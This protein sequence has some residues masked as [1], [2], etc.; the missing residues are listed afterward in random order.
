[1]KTFQVTIKCRNAEGL[2]AALED[3][4]SNVYLSEAE[5]DETEIGDEVPVGNESVVVKRV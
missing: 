3:L 5:V 2:H 4:A 1:M